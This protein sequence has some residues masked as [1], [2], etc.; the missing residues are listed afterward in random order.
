MNQL[1]AWQAT[2]TQTLLI[3]AA[4]DTGAEAVAAW[5][6]WVGQVDLERLDRGS[7]RMLPLLYRNLLRLKVDH[8]TMPRLKG[9]YLSTWARNQTALREL[10]RLAAE[11]EAA[12]ILTLVLKGAAVAARYYRDLGV[13]PMAD[14]D[15]LVRAG[16]VDAA[17]AILEADGW[18]ADAR[19]YPQ[20]AMPYRESLHARG[21]IHPARRLGFD[22]HWHV[23]TTHL[24]TEEDA[25]FWAA[26]EPLEIGQTR[27]HVLCPADQLLH[28]CIHASIYDHMA[29]VRW[30]PDA[31]VML[32]QTPDL[33]WTRVA[34]MTERMDATLAV[35]PKLVYLAEQW[36]IA[37]PPAVI[38]QLAARPVGYRTRRL[39]AALATYSW[40]RSR[41][42]IFWLL[43]SQYLSTLPKNRRTLRPLG[44]L[45]FLQH[46]WL[47]DT[48]QAM[49][50][51]G[52]ARIRARMARE[53]PSPTP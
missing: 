11:F 49:V 29:Q 30:L 31:L 20:L 39:Y 10:G 27:T 28:L 48:P 53:H 38:A 42:Q 6:A 40:E 32:R 1:P 41:S 4:L 35:V 14:F 37:V 36:G 9:I 50:R 43:Y 44:F 7:Q 34:A 24:G 12:G 47:V 18:Q 45:R 25:A 21:F 17:L 8:P 51:G 13:R 52:W 46:R 16:D 33:D 19:T 22:L 15:I 2:P 23:V 3:R 26:A 5:E